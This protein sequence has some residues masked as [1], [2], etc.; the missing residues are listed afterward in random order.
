MDVPELDWRARYAR[1][2]RCAAEGHPRAAWMW[3]VDGGG[4]HLQFICEECERP[5]TRDR[6]ET[7]GVRGASVSAEWLRTTLGINPD[8]L[9]EYRRGLR[10]HLCYLCG[11]TDL[12]EFHHVAP[13]ALYGKDANKYPIVPMCETCHDAETRDFSDRLER[14]VAERIRRHD[15]RRARRLGEAA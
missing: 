15:E 7:Q 12:C 13:Q 1:D 11:R 5:V 6:Y 10:Y 8:E 3:R 2:M 4:R 9:P 14:Y